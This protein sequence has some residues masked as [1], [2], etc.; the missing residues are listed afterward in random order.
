MYWIALKT[1]ADWYLT[2]QDASSLLTRTVVIH[3]GHCSK[4][5][6]W[7]VLLY[8]VCI[9]SC[10]LCHHTTDLS[11]SISSLLTINGF[12]FI[13]RYGETEPEPFYMQ[14]NELQPHFHEF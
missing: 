9:G 2:S 7:D 14:I 5:G 4:S 6:I 1:A 11:D 8:K 13:A 3:S 10:L 12:P